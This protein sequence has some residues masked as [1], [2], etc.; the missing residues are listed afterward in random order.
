MPGR[1][2]DLLPTGMLLLLGLFAV[3]GC[4]GGGTARSAAGGPR[5]SST[6][7]PPSGQLPPS[8]R[9]GCFSRPSACG[10]P[11][12]TNTGVPRGSALKAYRGNL[13]VSTPGKVISGLAVTGSVEITAS[14]VTIKDTKVT[15]SG[16][17]HAIWIGP[18]AGDVVIEDSTVRGADAGAGAIQYGI[19]NAGD[20]SNRGVRLDLHYCAECWA[21]PGTLRDSYAVTNGKIAGAHYEAIYYGGGGGYLIVGHDTLFNPED[22]TSDVFTNTDFGD[23][24]TV[25]ITNNL[26]A[27]GGYMIY[28]GAGGSAGTV[29][30]PVTVTGNRFAAA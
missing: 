4:G 22:Q 2:R 20:T 21:G 15:N 17:G 25:T 24:D 6:R 5:S 10:Y 27:G 3:A 14:H 29:R 13:N 16:P 9:R 7:Q 28:G 26:M 19:Q 12:P 30:G 18:G 1:A 11:D 23:V 8:T